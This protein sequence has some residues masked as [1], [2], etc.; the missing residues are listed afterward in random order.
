MGENVPAYCEFRECREV[1]ERVQDDGLALCATHRKQFQ[2]RGRLT[3]IQP[4]MSPE[5]AVLKAG[6]DWLEAD[7]DD[8][9]AYALARKRFLSTAERWMRARGWR[10]ATPCAGASTRSWCCS[11]LSR[12]P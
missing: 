8:D 4:R 7:A 5:E 6:G 10:Q 1:A 9:E 12:S 2:R 11:S 3:E